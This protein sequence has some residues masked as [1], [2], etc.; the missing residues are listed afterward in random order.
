MRP[1]RLD[2][3]LEL[4]TPL[5]EADGAGGF[6]Q[7]WRRV[8]RV[9]AEMRS[10]VGGERVSGVAVQSTVTWR[11]VVRAAVLGDPR[12]PRAGQRL[13]MAGGRWFLIRSVAE[14]D[15]AGR[16]LLCLASEEAAPWV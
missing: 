10:G 6:R 12:R 13:G 4:E 16:Y 1:P 14:M 9:W 15:P 7:S 2:V 11:I 3:P 5:S 8:G